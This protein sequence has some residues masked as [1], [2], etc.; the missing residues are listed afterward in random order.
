MKIVK[1]SKVPKESFVDPVFTGSE[2]TKQLLT[3]G[4]K[5]FSVVLVNFGKGIRAKL[6]THDADQ[7]L[8]VTAGKGLVGTEKEEKMVTAGDVVLFHAG[9]K[10]WHGATE[11]SEF[12]HIAVV[13]I[14]S[15]IKIV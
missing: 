10:H 14:G 5:E 7:I 1:M 9:E 2:V 3:P 11:D 8:I 4:S 6:H 12:S 15:G 13:K